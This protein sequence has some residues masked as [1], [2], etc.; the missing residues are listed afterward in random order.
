MRQSFMPTRL[1]QRG[2]RDGGL[3]SFAHSEIFRF[4]ESGLR[5]FRT[6]NDAYLRY[7]ESNAEL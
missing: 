5:D 4:L 3:S 1:D 2:D 7:P 6:Y